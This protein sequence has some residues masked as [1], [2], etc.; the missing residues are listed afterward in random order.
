MYDPQASLRI[1]IRKTSSELK[2]CLVTFSV[3]GKI[4]AD[5]FVCD[6][7]DQNVKHAFVSRGTRV[8]KLNLHL[9]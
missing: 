8:V 5:L 4:E 1:C 6:V 2:L 9:R 7:D 3:K